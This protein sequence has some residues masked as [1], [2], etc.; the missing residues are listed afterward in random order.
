M[1]PTLSFNDIF[2]YTTTLMTT[3]AGMFEAFGLNLFRAF[4]VMLL[5]WFGVMTALRG[6]AP[7]M[8]KLAKLVLSIATGLALLT[9]YSRPMPIIGYSLYHLVYDQ[10]VAFANVLNQSMITQVMGRLSALF[11]NMETPGIAA[12]GFNVI[13]V[14]RWMITVIALLAAAASIYIV[15]G[16]S[17]ILAGIAI[18]LGPIFVPFVIVPG[19]TFMFWGWLKCLLVTSFIQVTGAAYLF[20]MGSL[21]I[22]TVDR[23]GTDLSAPQLALFSFTLPVLLVAF[24]YGMLKIPGFTNDLF[25][26]RGGMSAVP[27]SWNL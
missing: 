14:I 4:A 24:A 18:L 6:G 10:A 11:S 13:E 1:P 12:V 16:M 19:F 21:L 8:D 7:E 5:C 27:S 2:A 15:V 20:V 22:N 9:F 25:A 23:A 17:F 26:G 3:H